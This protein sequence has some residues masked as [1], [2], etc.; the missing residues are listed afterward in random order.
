MP[1]VAR[2]RPDTPEIAAWR[3]KNPLRKYLSELP[4]AGRVQKIASALGVTVDAVWTYGR[5]TSLPRPERLVKLCRI[6][7]VK[8]ADYIAWWLSYPTP[9]ADE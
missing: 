5:G 7:G 1:R 6:L 9:E 3:E 4:F 2:M 8:K